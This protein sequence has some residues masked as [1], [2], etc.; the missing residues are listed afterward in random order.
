MHAAMIVD[1]VDIRVRARRIL[2]RPALRAERERV[3]AEAHDTAGL[4]HTDATYRALGAESLLAPHWP[5]AYGGLGADAYAAAV[6]AEELALH[7]IPDSARVNTIDNA[8]ATILAA[9]TP[10][11]RAR[12]LPAMARGESVFAVLYTE[13][14]VGSDLGG[15][16]TRAE[17]T[18]RGWHLNGVKAWN[19]RTAE[20]DHAICA[21]RTPGDSGNKYAD[22]SL[23]V[24]PLHHPG[25]RIA[26]VPTVNPERFFDVR[27]D[28][29]EVPHESLV[30]RPGQG[31]PLLAQALGLERTGICFAG[32]ARRWLDR[33]IACLETDPGLPDVRVRQ[34]LPRLDAEVEACRLLAWRAVQDVAERRPG[35]A[36]A[37]AAK[38]WAS[39]LAQRVAALA[40]EVLGPSP[41]DGT[42][43][44]L[45][46]DLAVAVREAPGLSLAAGTSE[47]L[48]DTVAGDLLDGD[49][50]WATEEV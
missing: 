2:D 47:V 40:W 48:L 7:G 50:P 44:P 20:A 18:A 24:V 19:A 36:T 22:I 46:P 49:D 45:F 33:L 26:P 32:R 13:P 42:A 1:H 38:W 14:D 15:L 23:F 6:V 27:L 8:G 10:A 31:W 34:G 11:Q 43:H 25:V 35:A 5:R 4:A 41:A 17:P 28:D 9:G 39:E 21:A 30:G 29:V 16:S 3:W 12:Y 37:A